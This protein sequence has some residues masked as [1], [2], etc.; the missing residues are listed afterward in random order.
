[1]VRIS[2][3]THDLGH[4][5]FSH[6][7]EGILPKQDNEKPYKHEA[8]S[9]ALIKYYLK[10]ILENHRENQDFIITSEEIAQFLSGNVTK[11]LAPIMPWR[12]LIDGEL[13][14]DRMDYL[15][16][17]SHHLGVQ[18]GVFDVD[19]IIS[20]LTLVQ[21]N[22]AG[23]VTIGVEEGG[24][25]AIESLILAR[26]YMF[27]QVYFHKVRRY[28]D[29]QYAEFMRSL[30]RKDPIAPPTDETA[31]DSYIQRDDW[32]IQAHIKE[33]TKLGKNIP[34]ERIAKRQCEKVV[35]EVI[36]PKHSDK[37]KEAEKILKGHEIDFLMDKS[38]DTYVQK[39][40]KSN[41]LI[42]GETGFEGLRPITRCS[43]VAMKV[44][45]KIFIGR[46]Y[47]ASEDRERVRKEGWLKDLQANEGGEE[48]E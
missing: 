32:T 40:N 21:Q 4:L 23:D 13:D 24:L 44:P 7:A 38:D 22:A 8:Y 17:D 26:Y 33:E 31:L 42:S 48:H 15:R 39:F 35:F 18:Y 37:L 1:M 47:V 12:A 14:C 11:R 28:L 6:A 5:P 16:R 9:H 29:L 25:L 36:D 20:T 2:A 27:H 46:L 41:I 43:Q 45:D 10:D 34:A 30:T 3:L 19:R